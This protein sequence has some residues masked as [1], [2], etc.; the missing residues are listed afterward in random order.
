MFEGLW[1]EGVL[2]AATMIAR[3]LRN[4]KIPN[5]KLDPAIARLI[6]VVVESLVARGNTSGTSHLLSLTVVAIKDLTC[7][8]VTVINQSFV[9]LLL[10]H[11]CMVIYV[12]TEWIITMSL[13]QLTCI[14]H[15]ILRLNSTA[16]NSYSVSFILS[17]NVFRCLEDTLIKGRHIGL[18]GWY[19]QRIPLG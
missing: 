4:A 17:L 7:R 16:R 3:L 2:R 15:F 19:D 10:R 18:F 14:L 6:I 11:T 13:K 5:G 12:W 8:S 1:R 9:E